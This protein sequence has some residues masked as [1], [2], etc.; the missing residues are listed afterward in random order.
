[1]WKIIYRD[2]PVE[3]DP[4]HSLWSQV[5]D[6]ERQ[7]FLVPSDDG[8]VMIQNLTSHS[9]HLAEYVNRD[10]LSIKSPLI[11]TLKIWPTSM[12]NA[13]PTSPI[14]TLS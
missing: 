8:I 3:A 2:R 10:Y 9:V 7:T 14:W 13:I 1:M 12:H 4:S 6:K 11:S 5:F